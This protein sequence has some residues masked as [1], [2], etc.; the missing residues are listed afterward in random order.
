MKM[1]KALR[2]TLMVALVGTITTLFVIY[3]QYTTQKTNSRNV[4]YL[5]LAND[6]SNRVTKAHLWFEELLAGDVDLNFEND[7]IGPLTS[8]LKIL[9]GAYDGQPTEL[10]DFEKSGDEETRAIL[11]EAIIENEKLISAARERQ[12]AQSNPSVVTDS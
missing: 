6:V 1:R 4:S 10:G 12:A 5:L 3:A 8:S 11:K 2:H 7:V 9:Q